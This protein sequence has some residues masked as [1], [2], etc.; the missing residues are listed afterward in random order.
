MADACDDLGIG[1]PRFV[2]AFRAEVGMNPKLFSRLG[3]FEAA[4]GRVRASGAPELATVAAMSGYADQ[5]HFAREFRQLAG[6][7]PRQYR[8]ESHNLAAAFAGGGPMSHLF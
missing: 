5:S 2:S 3:R 6:L 7:S 4:V 1:R 8:A